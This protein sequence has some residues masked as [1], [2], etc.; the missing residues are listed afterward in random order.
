MKRWVIPGGIQCIAAGVD[1]DIHIG[2][3]RH[4]RRPCRKPPVAFSRQGAADDGSAQGMC[5]RFHSVSFLAKRRALFPRKALFPCALPSDAAY[6]GTVCWTHCRLPPFHAEAGLK[7]FIPGACAAFNRKISP[8]CPYASRSPDPA[9]DSAPR[10]G[11]WA[12]SGIRL[13]SKSAVIAFGL[14][15]SLQYDENTDFLSEFPQAPYW[16]Y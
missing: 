9:N 10:E 7:Y 15:L 14:F 12:A 2:R 1:G 6:H 3:S 4:Q 16:A 8:D 11:A 13:F 5:D